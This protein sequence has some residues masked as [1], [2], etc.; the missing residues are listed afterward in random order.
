MSWDLKPA[1]DLGLTTKQRLRS[2]GRETG[3]G[4]LVL[5]YAWRSLVRAHLAVLHRLEVTGRENLPPPP[6]VLVAN[7]SSHLDAL[8]LGAV[9]RG[10]AA[11]RAHALAAGDTFFT[12]GASSAFAAY[13]LNAFP[14]WRKRTC[15]GAGDDARASHRG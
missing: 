12:S 6:F 10:P 13:A 9:L 3:L 15:E 5:Q 8:T 1:P 14:V 2:H 11:R 7:H 4:S